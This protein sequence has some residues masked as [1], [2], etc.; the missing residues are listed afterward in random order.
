MCK[1]MF[2]VIHEGHK[3][4]LIGDLINYLAFGN[5]WCSCA[6]RVAY[7]SAS[8]PWEQSQ[9]TTFFFLME[10]VVG[11]CTVSSV[12]SSSSVRRTGCLKQ[13]SGGDALRT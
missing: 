11:L 6:G 12:R 1:L 8:G 2:E 9:L 4:L 5:G 13:L 7:T 3:L 10:K